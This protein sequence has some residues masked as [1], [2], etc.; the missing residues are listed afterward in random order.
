MILPGQNWQ[1]VFGQDSGSKCFLLVF[2]YYLLNKLIEHLRPVVTKIL[3]QSKHFLAELLGVFA[4]CAFSDINL[5]NLH[6]F[7]EPEFK[8]TV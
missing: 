2:H 8:I 7:Q 4:K 3:L 1:S 6:E 5:P